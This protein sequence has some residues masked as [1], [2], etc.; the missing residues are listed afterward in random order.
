MPRPALQQ[1]AT[2]DVLKSL[3]PEKTRR[4][5][6]AGWCTLFALVVSLFFFLPDPIEISRPRMPSCKN[7]LKILGVVFGMYCQEHRGLFP[8]LSPVPGRLSISNGSGDSTLYPVCMTDLAVLFCTEKRGMA[9]LAEIRGHCRSETPCVLSEAQVFLDGSSYIYLGY[10]VSSDAD[11]QVFA[12]AYRKRIESGLPFREDLPVKLGTGHRG[13]EKIV[14]L[15]EGV[16]RTLITD[17]A[18]PATVAS[19]QSVLPVLIE[20]LGYHPAGGHVL[21]L[22]GHVEF[23]PYPGKWPM[24][25][26]TMGI[27]QSLQALRN[28]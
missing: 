11:V 5:A 14:L 17:T 2:P 13:G 28:R 7:N 24:T 21:Y 22:D 25:E 9:E 27:L 19:V 23:I 4:H 16:E 10:V 18:N 20:K 15:R 1:G 6:L 3:C 26:K 12:D 8:E